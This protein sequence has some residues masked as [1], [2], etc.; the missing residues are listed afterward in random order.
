M[1]TKTRSLV[2][3]LILLAALLV[4]SYYALIIMSTAISSIGIRDRN[5]QE[6]E[7]ISQRI[8]EMD[9]EINL[10][11]DSWLLKNN[12]VAGMMAGS[13]RQLADG[14][15]YNGPQIFDDGFVVQIKNDR[16]TY[17]EGFAGNIEGLT[18]SDVSKDG[19]RGTLH[20]GPAD[21]GT[22]VVYTVRRIAGDY[23]YVDWTLYS[24]FESDMAEVYEHLDN[25]MYEMEKSYNGYFLVISL[26]D[27]YELLYASGSF[28]DIPD[29][30]TI[31]DIGLNAE[32]I[33]DEQLTLT[34]KGEPYVA[35]YRPIRFLDKPA[36]VLILKDLANGV[37][38][39]NELVF[40]T[41]IMTAMI[42]VGLVLWLYWIQ[43]YVT[44]RSLTEQQF[45]QYQPKKI[46]LSAMSAV[47]IGTIIIFLISLFYQS[48]RNLSQEAVTN[49]NNL[50]SLEAYADTVMNQKTMYQINDEEW[51]SYYAERTAL[52][53]GLAPEL[54]TQETLSVINRTIGSEY[55][56]LYDENGEEIVS[57]NSYTGFSLG[58]DTDKDPSTHFRRLLQGMDTIVH[59]PQLDPVTEKNL[60]QTGARVDLG[61]KKSG[62]LI[63]SFNAEKSWESSIE[64][65]IKVF[66]KR[67][68]PNEKLCFITDSESGVVVYSSNEKIIN[69]SVTSSELDTGDRV[70]SDMDIF[71]IGGTSY[72]GPFLKTDGYKYYYLTREDQIG[73]NSVTFSL[74]SAG[75]FLVMAVIVS[76][77]MLRSYRTKTYKETVKIIEDTR[78]DQL[79]EASN[80]DQVEDPDFSSGGIKGWWEALVPEDRIRIYTQIFAGLLLIFIAIQLLDPKMSEAHSAI[81]FVLKGNWKRGVNM[82]AIAAAFLINI[83]CAVFV[84]VKGMVVG[85]LTNVMDAKGVTVLRLLASLLQYAVLVSAF[86]VLLNYF[87]VNT[88]VMLAGFSAFSLA[89][90]LGGKDLVADVLA[91]IFIIFEDDFRVGDYIEVNGFSG[92]VQDI[93]VR[94][95]KIL[96]L[97]D[98][99]KI[100]GNQNIKNVLNMSKM[101]SWYTMEFTVKGD[102]P[103]EKIEEV[104]VKELPGIGRSI[105]EIISGP[106]YKGVWAIGS[107]GSFTLAT[108]CECK[109]NDIRKVQRKLNHEVILLFDRYGFKLA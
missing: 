108:I 11:L 79:M 85:L 25:S 75:V 71:T 24:E 91:G 106:F 105:P 35:S 12:T 103:L 66:I 87:G 4:L 99:I 14:S 90:S 86:F 34:V 5:T 8:R 54:R 55:I 22:D 30:A 88:T 82:L 19:V 56:M 18:S 39:N 41:V 38:E 59:S 33:E 64:E 68:T 73:K 101:N 15:R 7:G 32:D 44:S 29:E 65:D 9:R 61:D 51:T 49:R 107:S 100:I 2:I 93:G 3:S 40:L 83:I 84:F 45:L 10:T 36:K 95:T 92:I 74:M 109:E 58:T 62:A 104:L 43:R 89:I 81:R 69:S 6:L 53:M 102:Q 63:I 78:G 16:V 98:N 27:N 46:R 48:L 67:I 20:T 80:Q 70:S 21:K 94:S 47:M 96:G 57:S 1:K 17:P 76:M 97:G 72:Y 52:L 31:T 37:N 77:I 28:G 50:Q 60:Q 13:L 42:L 26:T 23:F